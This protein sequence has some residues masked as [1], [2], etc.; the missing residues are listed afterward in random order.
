MSEDFQI[1][2]DFVVKHGSSSWSRIEGVLPTRTAK[3]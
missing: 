2:L 1:L 3:H